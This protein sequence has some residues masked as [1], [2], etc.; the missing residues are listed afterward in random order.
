MSFLCSAGEWV[1]HG[2]G[3]LIERR[4]VLPAS[5]H[6]QAGRYVW[7]D[8]VPT[9]PVRLPGERTHRALYFL[10]MYFVFMHD[11]CAS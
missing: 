7:I 8:T 3:K 1:G 10:H 5:G 9:S 11:M 4:R 6:A 2:T